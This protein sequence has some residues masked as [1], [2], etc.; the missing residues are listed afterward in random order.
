M[1]QSTIKLKAKECIRIRYLDTG[2]ISLTKDGIQTISSSSEVQKSD[3][4]KVKL[5]AGRKILLLFEPTLEFQIKLDHFLFGVGFGLF[6]NCHP[7]EVSD[8]MAGTTRCLR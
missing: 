7:A 6:S 8:E 4:K 3:G 1:F 5:H 2:H